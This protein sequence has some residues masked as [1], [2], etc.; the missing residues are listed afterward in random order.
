M[1][2]QISRRTARAA[3]GALAANLAL[4]AV[5]AGSQA[6]P[7]YLAVGDWSAD[8]QGPN[9]VE[10]TAT[11]NGAIPKRPDSFIGSN[12]IVGIAWLDVGTLKALVATIHPVIGRDSNQRPDSWHLH[13]VTLTAAG[14]T[15]PNDVCLVSVD[16][17]PTGGIRLQGSTL[18]ANLLASSLPAS[19]G[20]D[21]IDAAVGFTV[22]GDAGC[23]SGLGVRVRT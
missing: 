9:L 3:I 23:A 20:A 22:H 2:H 1:S 5:V 16:S 10:L 15:A 12:A 11:T 13:T 21:D 8:A 7:G 19:V 14:A 17:T 18:S 6:G 4:A